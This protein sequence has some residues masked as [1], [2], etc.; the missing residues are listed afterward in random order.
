MS[1]TPSNVP[2]G[3]AGIP[4]A[5][6][7]LLSLGLLAASLWAA[8]P[9]R[10][11]DVQ[12][13]TT[14]YR[15]I[16]V[17]APAPGVVAQLKVRE[18]DVVK[19]GQTVAELN[20]EVYALGLEIAA[21]LKELRGQLDSAAADLRMKSERLDAL[22][23]LLRGSHASEEEVRRAE[24]DREV[25][26]AN[27]LAVR[28]SLDVKALEWQ[29]A[30]AQLDERIIRSPID[31]VVTEIVRDE[32]EYVPP[33]DPAILMVVQLD[34][35][36]ATFSVPIETA[37]KLSKGQDVLVR[38]YPGAIPVK[39]VLEY[40][41]PV[42]HPESSTVTVKAR[43]PNPDGKVRSGQKCMLVTGGP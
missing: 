8:T 38:I 13:F 30:K 26:D 16:E 14:P 27:L 4:T 3:K 37:A 5:G 41:S 23:V 24:A 29:R 10:C 17:A 25:A 15:E 12:G 34:P 7:R 6:P 43:L 11:A 1:S 21:R 32:G 35:L 19:K 39:A 40:V 20:Q 31:G 18:G 28:E 42:I 22:H 33:T 36:L 9:G 2:P